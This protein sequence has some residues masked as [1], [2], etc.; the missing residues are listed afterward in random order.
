MLQALYLV[1]GPN[2]IS[3]YLV[4]VYHYLGLVC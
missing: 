3:Q 2:N 4:L 1:P